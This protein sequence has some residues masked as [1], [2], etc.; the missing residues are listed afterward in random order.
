LEKINLK[1]RLGSKVGSG[2]RGVEIRCMKCQADVCD[3]IILRQ[4]SR[5]DQST[6]EKRAKTSEGTT[7]NGILKESFLSMS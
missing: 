1:K 4:T 3:A 7:K 6:A 2:G 5:R